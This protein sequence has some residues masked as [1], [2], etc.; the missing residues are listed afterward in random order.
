V[1][2]AVEGKAEPHMKSSFG[3][4][5]ISVGITSFIPTQDAKPSQ[6]IEVADQALYEATRSGR[7]RVCKP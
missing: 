1:R 4:V 6:Y 7:T 5:T 2:A 3:I